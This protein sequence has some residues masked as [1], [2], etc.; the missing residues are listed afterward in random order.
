[1]KLLAFLLSTAALVY[2]CCVLLV[3]RKKQSLNHLRRK[4]CAQ[5]SGH[6]RFIGSGYSLLLERGDMTSQKSS[7][8][9]FLRD[10]RA[11]YVLLVSVAFVVAFFTYFIDWSTVRLERVVQPKNGNVEQR[12][13]GSISVPTGGD[14]CWTFIFD[15]RTGKMR[16]G[17]YSKC[18]KAT[19]QLDEKDPPQGMD[20]LRLHEV[21][22][23]FRNRGN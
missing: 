3:G 7:R 12:Y 20:M 10:V 15:N 11:A 5:L 6:S 23:A 14:Q 1:M 2:P 22:R 9:W 13:T 8:R 19:R 18:D 21:S 4:L 16:D 17:G